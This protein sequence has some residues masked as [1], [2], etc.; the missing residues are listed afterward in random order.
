MASGL[1]TGWGVAYSCNVL[2]TKKLQLI[3]QNI[4][5]SEFVWLVH[6]LLFKFLHVKRI[7]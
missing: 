2:C 6:Y 7:S 1:G 5:L 3:W 4:K